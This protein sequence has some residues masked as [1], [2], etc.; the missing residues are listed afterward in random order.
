V[1]NSNTRH[2]TCVILKALSQCP[3][4]LQGNQTTNQSI[5]HLPSFGATSTAAQQLLVI[6]PVYTQVLQYLNTKQNILD[7]S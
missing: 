7:V 4:F 3:L 5:I 6:Y 1:H 2:R